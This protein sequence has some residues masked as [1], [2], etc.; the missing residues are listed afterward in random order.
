[1]N[2]IFK[3]MT[4]VS[5]IVLVCFLLSLPCASFA[6]QLY[7]WVDENGNISYQ[8][9][10]P[11]EDVAVSQEIL[12]SKSSS[13]ITKPNATQ[14]KNPVIVYTVDDCDACEIALLRLKQLGIPNQEQSLLDPDVQA[15]VLSLSGSLSAPTIFIGDKLLND[16]SD[17]NLK[18]ELKAAGYIIKE[19]SNNNSDNS[20]DDDFPQL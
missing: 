18:T 12:K 9:Q 15:R 20:V 16:N 14:Y 5:K 6:D 19:R 4:L 10:P 8:D 3:N 13:N 7:K 1:M 2:I 17:Q 11:P